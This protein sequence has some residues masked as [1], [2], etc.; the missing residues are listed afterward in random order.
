M[1]LLVKPSHKSCKIDW[2]QSHLHSLPSNGWLTWRWLASVPVSSFSPAVVLQWVCTSPVT[3]CL[4][5]LEVLFYTHTHSA[6]FLSQGFTDVKPV[7]RFCPKSHNFS[8]MSALVA[9]Q[10]SGF[11]VPV[12]CSEVCSLPP[13]K[14]QRMTEK[15]A[16]VC[17]SE[18]CHNGY[19][20]VH[21]GL[22][23]KATDNDASKG[24]G[25]SYLPAP[26]NCL[27]GKC[28]KSTLKINPWCKVYV[29]LERKKIGLFRKG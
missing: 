19:L 10:R 21:G 16:Q 23:F 27:T 3:H 17:G 9:V 26:M 29:K 11:P 7:F 25:I 15:R 2:F 4:L 6:A 13:S 14:V 24:L 5:L 20:H 22:T 28:I 12:C 18:G 8:V 1:A